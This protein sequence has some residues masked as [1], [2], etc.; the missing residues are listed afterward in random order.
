MTNHFW[1]GGPAAYAKGLHEQFLKAKGALEAKM[2]SSD[3][4]ERKTLE[5]EARQLEK[6]YESKR[7]GIDDCIF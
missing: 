6:D 4:E 5:K 7:D 3:E 2:A 1:E